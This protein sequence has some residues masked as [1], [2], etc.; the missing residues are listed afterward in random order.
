MITKFW[1]K[2][3]KT[4]SDDA[5]HHNGA[6][7]NIH[8]IPFQNNN[9]EEKQSKWILI[10]YGSKEATTQ[11]RNDLIK[12][13]IRRNMN[14]EKIDWIIYLKKDM[15]WPCWLWTS[16]RNRT[17]VLLKIVNRQLARQNKGFGKT[18]H[19]HLGLL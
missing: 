17:W 19:H 11:E 9:T 6:I 2:R 18:W 16:L 14:G 5:S 15:K 7:Q 3:T 1:G 12:W 10:F 8:Q 13:K 4:P